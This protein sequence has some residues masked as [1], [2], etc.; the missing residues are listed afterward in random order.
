MVVAACGSAA[1]RWSPRSARVAQV[2]RRCAAASCAPATCAARRSR[3]WQAM[4]AATN[5]VAREL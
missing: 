4:R 5:L 2:A 3:P 1:R